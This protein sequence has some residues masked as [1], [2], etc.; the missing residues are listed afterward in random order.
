MSVGISCIRHSCCIESAPNSMRGLIFQL[1]R[2]AFARGM[3]RRLQFTKI[4]NWWLRTSPVVKRLPGSGV[5]Y[6]ATRL[7]SIPL[8]VEMFERNLYDATLL[9]KDFSTFA[10]LGCNV[11]YFTCWLGHLAKERPIKGLM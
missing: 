10:D 1:S 5:A 2:S 7:E 4:A 8:A 3:A 11:G 9:P 6:R